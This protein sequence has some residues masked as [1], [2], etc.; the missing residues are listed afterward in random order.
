MFWLLYIVRVGT[1]LLRFHQ[2]LILRDSVKHSYYLINGAYFDAICNCNYNHSHPSG[3][4]IIASEFDP[5]ALWREFKLVYN[6]QS[7]RKKSRPVRGWSENMRSIQPSIILRFFFWKVALW[8]VQP[9]SDDALSLVGRREE[10]NAALCGLG[11]FI[12]DY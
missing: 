5:Y 11:R 1:F 3:V 12:H 6:M 8:L 10:K 2:Q 7:T 4:Y 9:V